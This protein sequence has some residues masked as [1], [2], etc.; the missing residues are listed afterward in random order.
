ME[1]MAE[2]SFEAISVQDIAARATVNR[3]TFYAHFRD[4]FGLLE[5]A[6]GEMI[7]QRLHANLPEGTSFSE[8]NLV[9]LISTV[10]EFLAEI[11]GHCPPPR[12]QFEPLMEKQVKAELTGL[13]TAWLAAPARPVSSATAAPELAAGIASWAIYG[14]AVQWQSRERRPRAEDF[15]REVVPLIL[16]SLK[17]A[18]ARQPA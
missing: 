14:A 15:A 17:A 3:A 10:C 1:L 4:K 5:D 12:A 11:G 7:R 9:R 16:A 13:L 8:R 6:M 2:K 18:A